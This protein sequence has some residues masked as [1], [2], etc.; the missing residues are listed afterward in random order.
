M[1]STDSWVK[2]SMEEAVVMLIENLYNSNWW[3]HLPGCWAEL[4]LVFCLSGR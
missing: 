3:K 4:I 2:P 1:N